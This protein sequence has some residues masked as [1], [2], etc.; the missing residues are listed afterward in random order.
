MESRSAG[1]FTQESG[2]S[3]KLSEI[4]ASMERHA[5]EKIATSHTLLLAWC[6]Q[7]VAIA[8]IPIAPQRLIQSGDQLAN[9]ALTARAEN[10]TFSTLKYGMEKV[11]HW[12]KC[13]CTV[14]AKRSTLLDQPFAEMG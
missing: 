4:V 8:A 13:V 11:V 10:A 3:E 7:T 2:T 12:A 14:I 6:V 5:Q 9:L 1:T